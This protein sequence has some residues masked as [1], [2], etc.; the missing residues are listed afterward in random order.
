MFS[1]MDIAG[2]GDCNE[3]RGATFKVILQISYSHCFI[4]AGHIEKNIGSKMG[5]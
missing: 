4:M 2:P 1:H 3:G 5:Q